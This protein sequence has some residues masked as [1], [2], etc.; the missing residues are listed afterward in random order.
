MIELADRLRLQA[1]TSHHLGL[2]GRVRRKDLHC[3]R[4]AEV[5]MLDAINDAHPARAQPRLHTVAPVDHAAQPRIGRR[6]HLRG[7]RAAE[8]RPALAA[9]SQPGREGRRAL[10]TDRQGPAA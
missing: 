6:G 10:R 9:K 8:Q 2:R 5:Q 4:L 3:G 1:K 7:V